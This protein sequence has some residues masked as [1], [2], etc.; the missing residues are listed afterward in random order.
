M[1]R[2]IPILT[3]VAV[4]LCAFAQQDDYH[5]FITNY[6]RYGSATLKEKAD[7]LAA[8][9]RDEDATMLYMI[10]TARPEKGASVEELK[11]HI[12]SYLKTGD[13]CFAK[14]EYAYALRNYISG[15]KLSE[16][17][18]DRPFLPLLY[19][20]IGNVYV[21]YLDYE[22]GK[23]VYM[24]GLSAAREAGD[25]QTA[26]QLLLNLATVNIELGDIETA[27]RDFTQARATRHAKDD[28]AAYMDCYISTLLLRQTGQNE[29]CI[30]LLK[31]LAR[32]AEENSLEPRF[33][34]HAYQELA[35]IFKS[36]N[37]TDSA[38]YYLDL[39]TRTASENNILHQYLIPLKS[40]YTLTAAATSTERMMYLPLNAKG[41]SLYIKVVQD[42]T[43]GVSVVAGDTLRVEA[44]GDNVNVTNCEANATVSVYTL[45]GRLAG[46]AVADA[47]GNASVSV[48]AADNV[49]VVKAG[50]MTV[51][52]MR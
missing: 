28:E 27:R 41:M 34:C 10:V 16:Q 48:N 19:K 39:C 36:E 31:S 5:K 37:N 6:S 47:A 44:N 35:D 51:K 42:A 38:L 22:K 9:G 4:S 7:S 50:K 12:E 1:K 29:R 17:M 45:D 40:Q 18:K 24:R 13:I 52:L 32:M 43:S 23:A 21:M 25:D 8:A 49:L 14:G 3:I 26:Y 20:N 15:L 46:T 33:R 2:I 11:T 30:P